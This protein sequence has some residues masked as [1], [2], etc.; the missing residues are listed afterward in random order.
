VYFLF[1][2]TRGGK[3]KTFNIGMSPPTDYHEIEG[4]V[5]DLLEKEGDGRKVENIKRKIIFR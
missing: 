4:G 1:C 5:Y 3:L 2:K